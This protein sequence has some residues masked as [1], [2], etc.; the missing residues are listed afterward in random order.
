MRQEPTLVADMIKMRIM[1][2]LSIMVICVVGQA[3][4]VELTPEQKRQVGD[5]KQDLQKVQKEIEQAKKEDAAY[6]GGLIKALITMRV[7]IL[8]TNEALIE[9]RIHAL[10]GGART[11]IVVNV[12]KSDPTKAA[13]LAKEIEAQKVKVAEAKAE[14]DK[15]A[16]G[17]V[18]ALAETNVTT[19]RNTLTMLEQQYFVA[20]YGLVMP[21]PSASGASGEDTGAGKQS[22]TTGN[23]IPIAPASSKE[24]KAGECLKIKTFDS[25]VLS[26]NN[27]YTELAWKVDVG[28]SCA[29]PYAVRVRFVIYDKDEFELDSD[30][31][32]IFVPANGVGKARGKM[33]VSPPEKARRMTRQGANISMQ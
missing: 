30:N 32:D 15:Y 19:A 21:I 20:K 14:S 8:K 22:T 18:K 11:N 10:E 6:R 5:L 26:S 24:P 31:Q 2:F 29:E 16:G 23:T 28:N 33:L 3:C 12:A 17:L 13:D 1:L 9:Q 27:V 7:E 25:S 4:A